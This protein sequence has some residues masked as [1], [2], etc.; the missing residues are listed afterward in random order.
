MIEHYIDKNT[1]AVVSR[2][3]NLKE[4]LVISTED[5][6]IAIADAFKYRKEI[7]CNKYFDRDIRKKSHFIISLS[8]VQQKP[9]NKNKFV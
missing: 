5:F 1:S 9:E 2:L 6:Y 7:G 8:L 3:I 4:R